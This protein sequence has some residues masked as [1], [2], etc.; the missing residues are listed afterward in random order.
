MNFL[1]KGD[2]V[3]VLSGKDKGHQGKILKV[4]PEDQKLIVEKVRMLKRHTKPNKENQQGGIQEREGL[5][6]WDKVQLV[7]MKCHKRTRI[8]HR[9]LDDK[10]KVRVCKKCGEIIDKL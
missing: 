8:G 5:I 6:S 4:Y 10:Q 9:I 7:C 3:T 2:T 1:K